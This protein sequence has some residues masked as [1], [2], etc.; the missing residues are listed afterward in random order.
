MSYEGRVLYMCPN[1]HVN[2]QDAYVDEH[3]SEWITECP[4]C[5]EKLE[6]IGDIDDT[7]G[8]GVANFYLR[9][10]TPGKNIRHVKGEGKNI[11]I[12]TDYI[13]ATYEVI[14]GGDDVFF[15]FNT[16]ERYS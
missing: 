12:H 5:S 8:D 13:P 11:I 1:G 6:R 4:Y 15:N 2:F 10:V 3:Y 16:G 9:E 14:R 7:N